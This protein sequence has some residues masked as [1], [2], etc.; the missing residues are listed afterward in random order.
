ML[1]VMVNMFSLCFFLQTELYFIQSNKFTTFSNNTQNI[2]T[3]F[4]NTSFFYHFLLSL[5]FFHVS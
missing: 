1:C 2:F 4:F 3:F 5:I